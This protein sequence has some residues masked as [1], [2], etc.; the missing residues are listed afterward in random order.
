MARSGTERQPSRLLIDSTLPSSTLVIAGTPTTSASSR[1]RVFLCLRSRFFSSSPIRAQIASGVV[2]RLP[3]ANLPP[4]E[5]AAV[6]VGQQKRNTPRRD[7]EGHQ[8][9][10]LG[11][12]ADHIRRPSAAGLA[13]P[14]RL[15]QVGRKQILHDIGHGRSAESGGANQIRPRARAALAQQFQNAVRILKYGAEPTACQWVWT[16]FFTLFRR[17]V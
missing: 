5:L 6:Q 15:D 9:S 8:A 13:L 1:S 3:S 10:A 16:F 17:K 4:V 2:L 12:E 7:F 11:F 14:K